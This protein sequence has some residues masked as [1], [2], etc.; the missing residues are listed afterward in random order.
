MN[1]VEIGTTAISCQRQDRVRRS[2][3][4]S[5]LGRFSISRNYLLKYPD[6]SKKNMSRADRDNLLLSGLAKQTGP[7]EFI[8]LGQVR[9]LHSFA[10]LSTLHITAEPKN[11]R[12]FL[13]GSFIWEH[14]GK[15]K[16]E[17]METPE[18]IG[19]RVCEMAG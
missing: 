6:G 11:L 19:M 15:R 14:A 5:I 7:Q 1:N 18:S 8:Y 9:T 13:A 17:L 2:T 3:R 10:E 4:C 12:R 16:R